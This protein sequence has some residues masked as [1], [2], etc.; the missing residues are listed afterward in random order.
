MKN[1]PNLDKLREHWI[2]HWQREA[3][4]A[5]KWVRFA[6]VGPHWPRPIPERLR[7]LI[8]GARLRDGTRCESADISKANGRCHAHGGSSTGPRTTVGKARCAANSGLPA[9]WAQL[10]GEPGEK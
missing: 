1:G 3:R 9:M 6:M 4:R 7:G 2:N 8:C 10:R 5:R